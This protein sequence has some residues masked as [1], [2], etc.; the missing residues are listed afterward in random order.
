MYQATGD[1]RFAHAARR[2]ADHA[3]SG[4]GVGLG[5]LMGSAGVGLALLAMLTDIPPAW[6]RA[7]LLSD[8]TI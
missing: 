1:A 3:L 5:L 2:W 6:D 7:L 4:D 8:K